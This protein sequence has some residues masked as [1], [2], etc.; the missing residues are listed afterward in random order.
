MTAPIAVP[1]DLGVY[2][3]GDAFGVDI[4]RATQSLLLA[5]NLCETIW[6]ALDATALGTVLAVAG[7]QYNNVTSAV[8]VGIGS[9]HIGYGTTGA[10]G[11]TRGI[12]GL[13]LSRS[14]KS[15]LRRMAGRSGAFSIDLLPDPWPPVTP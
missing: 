15:D 11:A 7:R 5:Q 14:D 6:P 13:Y 2:L 1:S 9:G 3:T 8:T 4:V 10:A 12:G